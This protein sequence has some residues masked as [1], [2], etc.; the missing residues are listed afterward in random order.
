[1]AIKSISSNVKWTGNRPDKFMPVTHVIF[2]MDGLLLD[3]ECIYKQIITEIAESYGKKYTQE[4]QLMVLGTTEEMTAQVVVKECGLPITKDEFLQKF[5]EMQTS[6]LENAKLMNGAE[7][8]V[9][10]LYNNKVP[11]AVATSSGQK[12]VEVKIK[13]H[14]PLFNLFH[15]IVMGSSD[16]EV[17][18]GKPAPDIFMVCAQRFPD[19]PKYERCLVFEDAP[20]G[21]TGAVAAGMQTVMVPDTLLPPEKTHHATLIIDSLTNFKP[22]LFG[23][24]PFK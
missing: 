10:H 14:K 21:V 4:I 16:P 20:N 7:R 17:K 2:D 8:L 9:K 22:E 19:K 11:I 18:Q 23:L 15:H 1:M 13:D 3:T 5:R 6:Y 24:P 12:S